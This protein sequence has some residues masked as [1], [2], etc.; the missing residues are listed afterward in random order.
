MT[1]CLSNEK[2]CYLGHYPGCLFT[3]QWDSEKMW[4]NSKNITATPKNP[5]CKMYPV[6]TN[7][8]SRPSREYFDWYASNRRTNS[9]KSTDV[10]KLEDK[11]VEKLLASRQTEL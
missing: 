10:C 9:H 5:K 8:C 6:A 1:Y 4:H 3:N 7:E 2:V 11:S